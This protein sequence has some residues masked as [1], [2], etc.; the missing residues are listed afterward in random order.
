MRTCSSKRCIELTTGCLLS[1]VRVWR[2]SNHLDLSG[3]GGVL[4]QG[5]W[6][7]VGTPVVYCS[8]HPATTLLEMLVR[9]ERS[10]TP[11][12]FRLL[13]IDLPDD[14]AKLQLDGDQL[15][16]DW[17]TDIDFTRSL[18]DE[19]LKRAEHLFML[20]PC[21]LVPFT[22]NVLLNSSHSDAGRCS[23]IE[24]TESSLDPRLIR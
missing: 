21:A 13:T 19:L 11:A 6:N 23:I 12:R 24:V 16:A 3:R 9:V 18:G 14:S 8:D 20:V 17:R 4:S 15:P 1:A 2:I 10:D 22:W 5:R 7:K